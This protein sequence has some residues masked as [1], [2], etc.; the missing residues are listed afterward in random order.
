MDRVARFFLSIAGLLAII[1][2]A[3]AA[4]APVVPDRQ[5]RGVV[6]ILPPIAV[7]KLQDLNFATLGVYGAGTATIDP[8]TDIMT[9]TGGVT[10][11]SQTPYSALFEAVAPTKSVVHIRA[12]KQAAIVTRVGGTETMTVDLFT[13]SGSSTRNVVAKE[14][15]EFSV[16]G[17]LHVNANQ[18]EGTY[19]GTF[20]VDLQY[21]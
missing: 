4:A 8:N 19:I 15:F 17:T 21:N 10:H 9:V 7:R 20:D 2:A 6:N 12:P 13:I 1:V 16:G 18:A 3:P 11:L 5:A 14:P